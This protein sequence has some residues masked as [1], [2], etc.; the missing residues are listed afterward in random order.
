[1][2]MP[3]TR[4]VPSSRAALGAVLV[5]AGL[6]GGLWS[7]SVS[8]QDAKPVITP[9][10]LDEFKTSV[11]P[12]LTDSCMT[13][14]NRGEVA[15]DLNM[16]PFADPKVVAASRATFEKMHDMLG[17]GKMPPATEEPLA[18]ADRAAIM[19]WIERTLAVAELPDAASA[20][21]G[22]VTSRRL[23]RTEYN[24]TIRD[25]LGV[26][27]RPADEFPID[28]SG[29]GFDNIGDVLTLSP[30]LMEKYMR[31]ARS[32]SRAAVYG[33]PYETGALLVRFKAKKDQDDSPAVGDVLPFSIRGALDGAYRFPVDGEYEFRWRYG[34]FRSPSA[35]AN[36]VA[37]SEGRVPAGRGGAARA[38]GAGAGAADPGGAGR[39]RIG[40]ARGAAGPVDYRAREEQ[41]CAEV[42]ANVIKFFIDGQAVYEYAVRGNTNCEYAR[43][44]SFVRT[45]ITAGEHRLRISWPDHANLPDPTYNY[46]PADNR[47][48]L[49]VD[50]LDI[51]GP[52]NPSKEPPAGF[53]T[54]FIC[55]APGKYSAACRREIIQNLAT[56]AFRRPATSEEVQRLVSLATMVQKQDSFEE[57]IRVVIEAILM[58]P[59]FLF[60]I[61]KDQPATQAAA[62]PPAVVLAT[63]RAGASGATVVSDHAYRI[64]DYELAS[65]LSYFLWSSMPDDELFALA[66]A[67]R[68]HEQAILDGQV[69]RMLGDPKA[70]ALVD[71]FGEQWLNL[72]E[73]DRTKPDAALFKKV[74]DE[75]LAAM[76]KETQLFLGEIFQQDRSVLDL[77]DGKFT[78][79]NGPLARYYGITG[80][81]GEDFQR[82]ELDGEQRSGLLTQASIMRISSYATR[83][84]PVIRGKWVLDNLLGSPPPPP[85]DG[86]PALPDG[87][88]ASSASMRERLAQHRANPACAACH[89]A[90]DP[91]GLSLENYDAAGGWRTRE[92][93]FDIDASGTLPDGRTI[94]GAKGLKAALRARSDAFSEHFAERL[95]TYGLGRGLEKTDRAALLDIVDALKA[96]GYRFSALVTGIVNSRPFQM[97]SRV[98]S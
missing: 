65:R 16:E 61:E 62:A 72:R 3:A 36:A 56:R 34:N 38:G 70:R 78:Y 13:C 74:D 11:L 42:P 92:G 79:L 89:D 67:N 60:R 20:D 5:C 21:P 24:N 41:A 57:S 2:T 73:M 7:V 63:S 29:Y 84:S 94:N 28:D 88:V 52:F 30:M 4:F 55:G 17:R 48:M 35:M 95:M 37:L 64:S 87:G 50:Y 31:A 91:I 77:I 98:R 39:G 15:G 86:V 80:V 49:F 83:T 53:K 82:V 47:R 6:G 18:A 71:N 27:L 44:E 46:D 9:A 69:K 75:L 25:L 85:P 58:S 26:T 43:G 10:A 76:R 40:G 45:K 14:H 22:R 66:R 19:K 97:R 12:I 23:N 59:N 1:M 51:R 90:M 93:N 96:R 54:I 81:N 68:L 8:G 33:E 32:V